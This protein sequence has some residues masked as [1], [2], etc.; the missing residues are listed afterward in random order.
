M[1]SHKVVKRPQCPTCG[2]NPQPSPMVLNSCKKRFTRDGGHRSISPEQT[3]ATYQHLISP[4]TGIL[5]DVQLSSSSTPWIRSYVA[6]HSFERPVIGSLTRFQNSSGGKGRT[7]EQA[8]AS[9]LCEAL[10]HYSGVYQG[11]EPKKRGSY[12]EMKD[13]AIHPYSCLL[14]SQMQYRNRKM[15]DR[16]LGAFLEVPR[17]FQE[18]E[19]I[20]WSPVW[21]FTQNRWKFLPTAS[22]YYGYPSK[23][24]SCI[25]N[26]NGCAAGNTKEEA[27]LHGFF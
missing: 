17:P 20:D 27:I 14:F 6:D 1:R 2:T 25:S 24:K 7:D 23:K 22:C 16:N 13:E 15:Q 4:L 3:F 10:E 5:R 12:L 8:K 11:D 19:E 18:K 26:S 21:S 9:A